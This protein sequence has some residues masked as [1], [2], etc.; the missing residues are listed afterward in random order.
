MIDFITT[1]SGIHF[2]PLDP[3]EQDLNIIDIAHALSMMTRA[4]GH[5]PEFYSVGQHSIAC[6]LEAKAR[7][8]SDRITLACLI[9]D[10]SEAYMSDITRPV[11]KHL[12]GYLVAEER[13]QTMIYRHY[14]GSTLTEEELLEVG[15]IDNAMLYHEFRYY[16]QLELEQ[17]RAE[18]QTQPRFY[19]RPF[20]EVER[21]Y[22]Q[23][24]EEL[25]MA[26]GLSPVVH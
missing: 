3:R 2:R 19:E 17:Y 26:L 18:I 15:C 1:Y 22:I 10:A 12:N 9:H 5:L 13:L 8:L 21:E 24:F 4:N 23:L 11:K 20:G 7:G 25:R 6:C 16:S 14:I